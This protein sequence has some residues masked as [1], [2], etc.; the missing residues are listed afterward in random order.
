VKVNE[1]QVDV[2]GEVAVRLPTH[3]EVETEAESL[4]NRYPAL[5]AP[6]LALVEKVVVHRIDP[7]INHK[8]IAQPMTWAMTKPVVLLIG[9]A[10]TQ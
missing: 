3:A 8:T 1:Q 2:D 7:R 4:L 9:C 6:F 10:N 5:S